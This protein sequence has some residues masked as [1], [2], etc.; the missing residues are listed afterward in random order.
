MRASLCHPPRY[1]RSDF[2]ALA[3][4]GGN[5]ATGFLIAVLLTIAGGGLVGFY[6]TLAGL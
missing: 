6:A 3:S 2:E 1:T 5:F 4:D